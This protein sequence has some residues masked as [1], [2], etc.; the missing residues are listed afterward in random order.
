MS[1]RWALPE[2][3]ARRRVWRPDEH[4][5][6]VAFPQTLSRAAQALS[7]DRLDQL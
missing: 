1:G 7:V 3:R 5:L 4:R 2:R 6:K